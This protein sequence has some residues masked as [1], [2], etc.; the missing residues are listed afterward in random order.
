MSCSNPTLLASL[1]LFLF[2]LV[3]LFCQKFWS[4]FRCS[5]LLVYFSSGFYSGLF[6][7]LVSILVFF[8]FCSLFKYPFLLVFILVLNGVFIHFSF[9]NMRPTVWNIIQF[10]FHKNWDWLSDIMAKWIQK[11][12]TNETKII[13]CKKARRMAY[14]LA[15]CTIGNA[16]L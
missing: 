7:L 6:L 14:F 10:L 13:N 5:F 1:F 9:R 15:Q 12:T 2:L 8:F 16:L 4:L 3:F 11:N